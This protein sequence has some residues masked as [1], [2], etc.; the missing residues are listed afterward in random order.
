[1]EN[2]KLFTALIF[3]TTLG[4]VAQTHAQVPTDY[5]DLSRR[6]HVPLFDC[7]ILTGHRDERMC[8]SLTRRQ[9]FDFNY[10]GYAVN[11]SNFRGNRHDLEDCYELAGSLL[12]N[13]NAIRCDRYQYDR[14]ASRELEQCE[15]TQRA[16][17][18]GHFRNLRVYEPPRRSTTTTTTT[19]VNRDVQTR[20]VT[21]CQ[22]TNYD[23]A[24]RR[25][26][27]QRR[28]V[29]ASNGR[30][31]AVVG[32]GTA[33][34]G[35]IL[36]GSNNGTARTIGAGLQIGGAVLA[37]YGLVQIV[38]ASEPLPHMVCSQNY[39][40]ETRMVTVERQQCETTRYTDRYSNRYYYEVRCETERFVTFEEFDPWRNGRTVT[41]TSTTTRRY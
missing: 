37:T 33:V 40:T 3:A 24:Y 10:Q 15:I 30:R 14:R 28:E 20:T 17:N 18:E 36:R 23:D 6:D 9:R 41:T 27:D 4:G 12:Y 2:K 32:V 22:A 8:Q 39:I 7:S 35:T 38:D 13:R 26:D 5:V 11:C 29:Q 21:T 31:N 34:V 25:W 16:Y 1:M 19:T